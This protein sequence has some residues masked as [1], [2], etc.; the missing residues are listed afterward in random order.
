MGIYGNILSSYGNTNNY[1][2]PQELFIETSMIAADMKYDLFDGLVSESYIGL[3]HEGK[4]WDAIKEI[5]HKIVQG[6]KHAIEKIIE[7][8]KSIYDKFKKTKHEEK[9]DKFNKETDQKDVK[10]AKNKEEAQQ[11]KAKRLELSDSQKDEYARKSFENDI[12]KKTGGYKS[13]SDFNNYSGEQETGLTVVKSKN[14]L[15]SDEVYKGWMD[16]EEISYYLLPKSKSSISYVFEDIF[17][18]KNGSESKIDIRNIAYGMSKEYYNVNKT[19]KNRSD[20]VDDDMMADK[21]DSEWDDNKPQIRTYAKRSDQSALYQKIDADPEEFF[22]DIQEQIDESLPDSIL[23]LRPKYSEY[24]GED[25]INLKTFLEK[26]ESIDTKVCKPVDIKAIDIHKNKNKYIYKGLWMGYRDNLGASINKRYQEYLKDILKKVEDAQREIQKMVDAG[27]K[28][29]TDKTRSSTGNGISYTVN[30][31][32]LSRYVSKIGT[33]CSQT[34]SA[35]AAVY[36]EQNRL[37]VAEMRQIHQV[38]AFYNRCFV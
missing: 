38:M 6:I 5:F 37:K 4:I 31:S 35:L 12:N 16:Y 8:G 17:G 10:V 29:Y 7:L 36:K 32:Y 2:D 33:F 3:I 1:R 25:G 27:T 28:E 14:I 30:V 9:V 26:C 20:Y 24:W 19:L 13:K 11:M 23:A 18:F 34:I 21:L 22:K 15:I